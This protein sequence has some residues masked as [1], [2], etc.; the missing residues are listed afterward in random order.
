MTYLRNVN[1]TTLVTVSAQQVWENDQDLFGYLQTVLVMPLQYHWVTMRLND[2]TS[3]DQ[4]TEG[5]TQLLIPS[6]T[7]LEQLRS[8][9][10]TSSTSS[11]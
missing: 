3:P 9:W 11:S 10:K 2:Y 5:V 6:S 4:F 8:A 1:T 7:T